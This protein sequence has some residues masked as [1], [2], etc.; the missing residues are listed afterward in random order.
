MSL[1]PLLN[2]GREGRLGYT[3][4]MRH[5]IPLIA[6]ALLAACSAPERGSAPQAAE[7]P[8]L[9]TAFDQAPEEPSRPL[10]S[11]KLIRTVDLQLR[12]DEPEAVA[13]QVQALAKAT[14]G[15]VASVN[16]YRRQEMLH[17]QITIK[18][19]V[20]QLDAI[21][22]RIKTLAA[23]VQREHLKTE[24]VTDRFVDLEAR[25][26]TLAVTETELQGLLA[27]SRSRGHEVEDIMAIYR[28]LTEIRTR[29][30]Q[31][32]AQLNT[33]VNLTTYSTINLELTPTEA[34]RQLVGDRWQPSA[35][36]RSSFRTLL[37]ALQS[38]ADFAIVF[39]IVLL[40]IGSLIAL[41]IWLLVKLRR[42][43]RRR[44]RADST[45]G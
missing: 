5:S 29:I 43:W 13:E 32:Q 15:Y 33:L 27:E 25:L 35:T 36:V 31:L 1:T 16:A 40:P 7:V 22:I 23:E 21:V 11:R 38:L 4:S 3:G 39:V 26:R 10:D 30:E 9:G 24:D 44:P 20:E 18:V 14:S 42:R 12:V 8:V 28:Q 34:A 17:Y 45:S 6:A 41:P 19:P 2:N 37:G